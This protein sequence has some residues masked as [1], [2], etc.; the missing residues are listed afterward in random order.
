MEQV[1]GL[2]FLQESKHVFGLVWFGFPFRALGRV[3][4]LLISV[5]LWGKDLSSC[6]MDSAAHA[7]FSCI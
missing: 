4:L 2:D 5:I 7:E 1:L 6:S 3:C